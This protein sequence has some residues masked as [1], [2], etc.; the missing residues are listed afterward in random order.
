[1]RLGMYH[2]SAGVKRKLSLPAVRRGPAFEVGNQV[3]PIARS[4]AR[5]GITP[6]GQ[7]EMRGTDWAPRIGDCALNED[8]G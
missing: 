1:M 6:S 5:K 3:C 4:P 7:G 8:A 2:E